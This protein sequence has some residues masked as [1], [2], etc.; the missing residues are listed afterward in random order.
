MKKARNSTAAT[1]LWLLKVLAALVCAAAAA[2]LVYLLI[3]ANSLLAPYRESL[4]AAI[5]QALSELKLPG[6]TPSTKD[7]G[8]AIIIA[9]PVLAVQ[10]GLPAES[11]TIAAQIIAKVI[12]AVQVITIS[13]LACIFILLLV[14]VFEGV[15]ATQLRFGRSGA[16]YTKVIHILRT[17][18]Y[19]I[20]ALIW[21][22][23]AALSVYIMTQLKALGLDEASIP[24]ARLILIILLVLSAVLFTL[25]F[26]R[27]I[28]HKD[29][30][31]VMGRIRALYRGDTAK[32]KRTHL[33]G[34]S[35]WLA[36]LNL[37]V[38]VAL[39]ASAFFFGGSVSGMIDSAAA[40]LPSAYAEENTDIKPSLTLVTP[41]PEAPQEADALPE[42]DDDAAAD[43]APAAQLPAPA[44]D[45]L[46]VRFGI[47]AAGI[48]IYLPGAFYALRAIKY[49][50]VASCNRKL[51]KKRRPKTAEQ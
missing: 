3:R 27:F 2:G 5:A 44:A 43:E 10:A 48:L 13:T 23:F 1:I 39:L 41:A 18:K 45:P 14:R 15:A 33:S 28:Y 21:L 29:I 9:A 26:L 49:F 30:A 37:I 36:I 11:F 24:T 31:V 47:D 50:M 40:S 38:A 8:K 46:P 7:L 42:P 22:G 12:G 25:R 4:E 34:V 51:F 19:G 6:Y 16:M 32:A 17:V 35:T 20:R